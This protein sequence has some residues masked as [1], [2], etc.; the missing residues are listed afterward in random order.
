[1]G[2]VWYHF[3]GKKAFRNA[4]CIDFYQL[5]KEKEDE[6]CRHFLLFIPQPANVWSSALRFTTQQD[7]LRYNSCR[8][9]MAAVHWEDYQ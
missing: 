1:M 5:E 6:V 3:I 7:A 8:V 2:W 9:Y 4:V